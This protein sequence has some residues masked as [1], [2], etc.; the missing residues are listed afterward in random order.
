M[1]GW[2]GDVYDYD[3]VNLRGSS[4]NDMYIPEEVYDEV[5]AEYFLTE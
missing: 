3:E 4:D 1:S 5:A 2:Y